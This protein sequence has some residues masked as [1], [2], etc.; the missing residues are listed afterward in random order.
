[1]KKGRSCVTYFGLSDKGY[2]ESFVVPGRIVKQRA[3]E[4][5]VTRRVDN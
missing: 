2:N 5:I 3:V 4:S 1:M